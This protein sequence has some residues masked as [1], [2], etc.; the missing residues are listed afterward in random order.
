M[1]TMTSGIIG[2]GQ[3]QSMGQHNTELQACIDRLLDGDESYRPLLVDHAYERLRLLARKLLAGYPSVRRWE[4]TDDVLQNAS[5]RLWKSLGDVKPKDVRSFFS[6]AATQIRRE[7][8]DLTRHYYGPQGMGAN[9][10]SND[11]PDEKQSFQSGISDPTDDP[12]TLTEW[13]DLHEKVQQLPDEQREIFGLLYYHGLTQPEAA[14]LLGI[15]VRTLKRRWRD[16]RESIFA[17][18][19]GS[20]PGRE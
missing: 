12:V 9:H 15:S 7:L 20:Q 4:Q 17:V 18:L 16:T 19:H 11:H 2:R 5:L 10:A 13:T 8:V 6:L 14:E 1:L 3:T